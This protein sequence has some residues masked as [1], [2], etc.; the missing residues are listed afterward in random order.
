MWGNVGLLD[1]QT[2]FDNASAIR[3]CQP[4]PVAFQRAN[5]SGGNRSEINVRAL[6]DFGLPRGFNILAAVPAAKISGNTSRALRARAKVSFVHSGFSRSAFWGLGLRFISF[7]LAFVG[8]AQADHMH[9]VAPRR[10]YHHMQPILDQT[11]RLKPA[12]TVVL[13]KIS[14]MSAPTHS[15]RAANSNEIPRTRTF[16]SLLARSKLISIFYCIY[17]YTVMQT[18][19]EAPATFSRHRRLRILRCDGASGQ[20]P[21]STDPK[22]PAPNR[23]LAPCGRL[24]LVAVA[25]MRRNPRADRDERRKLTALDT[26]IAL[27]AHKACEGAGPGA[28]F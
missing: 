7:D 3:V 11:Q 23:P 16:F 8:L 25:A 27:A 12:F 18:A 15:N 22:S 6:P 24:G 21:S 28:H 19:S 14:T 10:E 5:V 17:V 2:A 26:T 4:G 13:S 9:L 1:S 20:E